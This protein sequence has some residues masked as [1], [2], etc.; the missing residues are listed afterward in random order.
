MWRSGSSGRPYVVM[1]GD[2]GI[3]KS[4]IIEKLTGRRGLASRSSESFTKS[5][6]RY[7]S[8]QLDICDTPGSNPMQERYEHNIWIAQVIFALFIYRHHQD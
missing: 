4:T 6:L 2:I 5:S 7:H 8:D 1:I 3:G